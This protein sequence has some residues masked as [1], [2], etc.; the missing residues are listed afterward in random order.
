ML[1]NHCY[2]YIKNGSNLTQIL[3]FKANFHQ[4]FELFSKNKIYANNGGHFNP[5]APN[6]T[7]M[8]QEIHMHIA[9]HILNK[10]L[11]YVCVGI[12]HIQLDLFTEKKLLFNIISLSRMSEHISK[13]ELFCNK[14][15]T[16]KSSTLHQNITILEIVVSIKK[17]ADM[18]QID[19]MHI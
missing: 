18:K 4:E 3:N 14:R 7:Y 17:Y 16:V 13:S 8:L 12:L 10:I 19:A 2:P 6:A 1:D 11:Q 9:I 15:N 5:R